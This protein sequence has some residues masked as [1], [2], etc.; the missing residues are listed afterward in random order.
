MPP[1][2]D[3]ADQNNARLDRISTPT[4]E[5]AQNTA[6]NVHVSKDIRSELQQVNSQLIQIDNA[7]NQ[8]FAY[9][10]EGIL[11]PVVIQVRPQLDE[12]IQAIQYAIRKNC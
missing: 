11:T 7:L 8:G 1:I 10:T 4:S 9:L 3:V 2:Q 12:H 6:A 5:T